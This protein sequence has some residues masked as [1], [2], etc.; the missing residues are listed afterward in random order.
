MSTAELS[1][2]I[3]RWHESIIYFGMKFLL[4][5]LKGDSFGSEVTLNVSC[6]VLSKGFSHFRA[7]QILKV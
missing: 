2:E 5:K 3:G 4:L 7:A 6:A 1:K